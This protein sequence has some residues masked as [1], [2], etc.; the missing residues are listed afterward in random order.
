MTEEYFRL[1]CN[2]YWRKIGKQQT[3]VEQAPF[4]EAIAPQVGRKN[5]D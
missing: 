5:D 3:T 4:E 1:F 2:S